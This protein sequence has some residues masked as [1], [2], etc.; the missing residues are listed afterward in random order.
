MQRLISRLEE[1]EKSTGETTESDTIGPGKIVLLVNEKHK[2]RLKVVERMYSNEEKQ[3][4]IN[5]PI[6]KAVIGKRVGESISVDTPKGKIHYKI[7]SIE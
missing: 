7:E 4:S 6:G 2:L 1:E 5:S 3:I